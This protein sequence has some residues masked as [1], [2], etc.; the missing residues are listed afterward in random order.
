[1]L[2]V[3]IVDQRMTMFAVP[4]SIIESFSDLSFRAAQHCVSVKASSRSWF[5]GQPPVSP[6]I[7]ENVLGNP[8]VIRGCQGHEALYRNY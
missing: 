1:M 6:L 8:Q 7:Q 3:R 5:F 2:Q 4:L